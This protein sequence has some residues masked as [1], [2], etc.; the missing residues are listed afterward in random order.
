MQTRKP[1]KTKRK[2]TQIDSDTSMGPP[3][4]QTQYFRG[5]ADT[6]A[7]HDALAESAQNCETAD[8][9]PAVTAQVETPMTDEFAARVRRARELR[10]ISQPELSRLSTVNP[11]TIYRI[12]AGKSA[13]HAST[14]NKI[15]RA[16]RVSAQW[17]MT[18][19]EELAPKAGP[20]PPSAGPGS[21]G[22]GKSSGAQWLQDN[23]QP[24][25][26]PFEMWKMLAEDP[27]FI[28]VVNDR[29]TAWLRDVAE[30]ERLDAAQLEVRLFMFR[31]TE[32]DNDPKLVEALLK[33]TERQQQAARQQRKRETKDAKPA[34][35]TVRK[36][37]PRSKRG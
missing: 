11:A 36:A 30:R 19:D 9:N 33:L 3:A 37:R 10:E 4:T 15:A 17:L 22:G 29:E 18:G 34:P 23:A 16:L 2:S 26:V 28:G 27:H 12:E 31:V 24:A 7:P 25:P 5:S 13:A 32:S 6:S 14:V 1:V 35:D 8:T 21:F 20:L